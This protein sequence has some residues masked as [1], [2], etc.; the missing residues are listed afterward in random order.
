MHLF[1]K[2]MTLILKWIYSKF[3]KLCSLQEFFG[4]QLYLQDNPPSTQADT[5][6]SPFKRKSTFNPPLNHNASIETYCRLVEQDV[7]S[8]LNDKKKYR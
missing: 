6:S 4:P 5:S 1:L 8:L 7:E 3:S 2:K